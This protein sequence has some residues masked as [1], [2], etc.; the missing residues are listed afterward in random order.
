MDR[1]R[2]GRVREK[3]RERLRLRLR[4]RQAKRE[5]KTNNKR[6]NKMIRWIREAE[7]GRYE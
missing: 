7:R 3:D 1:E 6:D 2:I 4:Q 5:R